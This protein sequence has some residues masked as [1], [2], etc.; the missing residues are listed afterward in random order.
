M[1]QSTTS[2]SENTNLEEE[3]VLS[4]DSLTTKDKLNYNFEMGVNVGSNGNFGTFYKP[5]VT[6][7]VSPKFRINTGVVYL[8]STVNNYPVFENYQYQSFSGNISQY[9]AFVSGQYD[10]TDKLS[11]AGSIYYDMT[12]YN[13]FG[14]QSSSNFDNLGYAAS[15]EYRITKGLTISGEIRRGNTNNPYGRYSNNG[16]N[17]SFG[18]SFG[19]GFRSW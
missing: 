19:P 1:G 14:G 8:N 4:F 16:F 11:V 9:V 2:G 12:S 7:Q 3:Y 10:V 15:F 17:S 18:N 6:Y 5:S 13:T